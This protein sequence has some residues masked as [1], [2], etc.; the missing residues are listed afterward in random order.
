SDGAIRVADP[1]VLVSDLNARAV[2]TR[3]SAQI[4]SMTGFVNGGPLKGTGRVDYTPANGLAAQLSATVSGMAMEFPQGLRSELDA[5]LDLNVDVPPGDEEMPSGQLSGTITVLRSNYREPMA[6]V[7]GLLAALRT[8]QLAASTESTR[9]LD[10]MALDVRLITDEDLIVD[11][12]YGRFQ[13]GGDL[14]VIGTAAAPALSGRAELREGG[15]LFVGRN[16][17]SIVSG[18]IDFTNPVTIEPDL[19]VR[20]TTRAGGE[21]ISVTFSGAPESPSVDLRSTSN[22]DLGQAEVASLLLTGRRLEDLA[23]GDA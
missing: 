14:R 6:I 1:R 2:L 8:R 21:D 20:A 4:T 19:N 9:L 11:N 18:T 10:A 16:V 22:P 5:A 13:L 23:P 3:T 7:T 12:N 17:Y 15:Q